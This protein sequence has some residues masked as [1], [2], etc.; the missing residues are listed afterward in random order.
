MSN[1]PAPRILDLKALRPPWCFLPKTLRAPRCRRGHGDGRFQ[2]LEV[3]HRLPF[4]ANS[5]DASRKRRT[6]GPHCRA[7][8]ACGCVCMCHIDGRGAANHTPKEGSG[9]RPPLR[10][11]KTSPARGDCFL[12]AKATARQV[13]RRPWL[14]H[15]MVWGDPTAIE[16]ENGPSDDATPQTGTHV[17]LRWFRRPAQRML[18]HTAWR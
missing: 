3:V 1:P 12:A 17:G 15:R 11:G 4:Q 9:W 5:S 13:T 18:V 10:L 7:A 16:F 14:G 2:C 8:N 6:G